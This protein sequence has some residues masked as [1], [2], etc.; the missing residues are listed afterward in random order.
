MGPFGPGLCSRLKSEVEFH[1]L[2]PDN[3]DKLDM[4]P[5]RGLCPGVMGDAP[6]PDGVPGGPMLPP[7]LLAALEAAWMAAVRSGA[8]ESKKLGF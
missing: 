6:G 5:D 2:D 3:P 1:F 4:D 7:P 8:E